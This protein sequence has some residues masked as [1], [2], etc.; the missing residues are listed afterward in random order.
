MTKTLA[1]NAP[2]AARWR[3]TGPFGEDALGPGGGAPVRGG[4]EPVILAWPGP[5]T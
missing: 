4:K 2:T 3:E 1:E 5:G